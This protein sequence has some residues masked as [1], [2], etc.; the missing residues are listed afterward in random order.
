[1]NRVADDSPPGRTAGRRV[2]GGLMH[3]YFRRAMRFANSNRFI[4]PCWA[5]CWETYCS[6]TRQQAGGDRRNSLTETRPQ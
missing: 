5:K 4:A 1:M 2:G 6:G 3:A